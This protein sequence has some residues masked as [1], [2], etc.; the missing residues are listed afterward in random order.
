MNGNEDSNRNSLCGCREMIR[1][2]RRI[3]AKLVGFRLRMMPGTPVTVTVTAV[4]RRH[5]RLL[6]CRRMKSF[7]KQQ[8]TRP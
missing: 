5:G 7:V 1:T 8:D 6:P 4:H 3:P 2:V